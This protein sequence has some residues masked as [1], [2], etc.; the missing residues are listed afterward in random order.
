MGSNRQQACRGVRICGRNGAALSRLR[1]S[2]LDSANEMRS[3]VLAIH[4]LF[5]S[6]NAD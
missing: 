1:E 3:V 4:P 2:S 6:L 5:M